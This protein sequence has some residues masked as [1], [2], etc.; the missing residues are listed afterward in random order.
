MHVATILGQK[1]TYSQ[2]SDL[3]YT[4][5]TRPFQTMEEISERLKSKRFKRYTPQD[6]EY[7]QYEPRE[8]AKQMDVECM[9]IHV[10]EKSYKEHSNTLVPKHYRSIVRRAD[11]AGKFKW[12]QI[13]LEEIAYQNSKDIDFVVGIFESVSCDKKRLREYFEGS[14]MIAWTKI[15]D[16]HLKKYYEACQSDRAEEAQT[17]HGYQTLVAD[18]GLDEIQARNRFLGFV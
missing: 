15:E 12:L 4:T 11:E 7:P 16:H 10:N 3:C 1:R 18:K 13:E 6:R 14:H 2:A 8:F 9:S 17:D 5:K